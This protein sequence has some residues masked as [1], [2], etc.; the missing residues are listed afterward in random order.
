MNEETVLFG[1]NY[2]KGL[3]IQRITKQPFEPILSK[4]QKKPFEPIKK[5]KKKM[6]KKIY[7][8]IYVYVEEVNN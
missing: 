7:I 4:K 2:I 1:E 8:Y 5:I 6:E 3:K